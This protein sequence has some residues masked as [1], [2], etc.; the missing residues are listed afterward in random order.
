MGITAS[1]VNI[2]N[3]IVNL[4]TGMPTTLLTTC[5]AT[6]T[7]SASPQT[8]TPLNMPVSIVVGTLL[9][10]DVSNYEPVLVTA[11]TATT[12]TAI[13]SKNHG[14]TGP[15]TIG[16][17]PLLYNMVKLGEVQDGTDLTTYASVTFQ[18]RN[19]RRFDSGWQI[20]STPVFQIE[21]AADQTDSTV[22]ETTVMQAADNLTSLFASRYQL[23]TAGVYVT[24]L[25][26]DDRAAY[27]VFPNGR[28]YRISLIY[29]KCI[30][31]YTVTLT[32]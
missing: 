22:A 10:V 24:L 11:T 5:A 32:P 26:Q 18:S 19:T 12:F 8:V 30:N 2:A 14:T 9:Y 23:N 1:T 4:L 20:N 3:S 31:Q 27:R 21:T 7:A 13:F 25:D 28:I 16:M 15:W 17:G 6:I 29:V